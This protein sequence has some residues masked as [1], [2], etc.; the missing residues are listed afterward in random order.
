MESS[1]VKVKILFYAPVTDIY[2]VS[3]DV[4]KEVYDLV[5]KDKNVEIAYPHMELVMK[6][7]KLFKK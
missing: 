1:S 5:K 7:K 3:S 2:R 6:D 4:T